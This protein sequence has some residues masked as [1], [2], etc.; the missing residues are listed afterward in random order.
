MK[1]LLGSGRAEPAVL[2]LFYFSLGKKWIFLEPGATSWF[3]GHADLLISL[4]HISKSFAACQKFFDIWCTV[5][6]GQRFS[7]PIDSSILPNMIVTMPCVCAVVTLK[8][9]LMIEAWA[10]NWMDRSLPYHWVW[11]LF[12]NFR[13]GTKRKYYE[14]QYDKD[15]DRQTDW[16]ISQRNKY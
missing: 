12:D 9:F 11:M 7:Y 1:K 4:T 16:R 10:E 14:C 8:Y 13:K 15:I 3:P 6:D 2:S 5:M